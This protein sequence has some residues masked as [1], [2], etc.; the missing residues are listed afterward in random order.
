M[1]RPGGASVVVAAEPKAGG[2]IAAVGEVEP[3][4]TI[5]K[6]QRLLVT[7]AAPA[8]VTGGVAGPAKGKPD[9]DVYRIDVPGAEGRRG[10]APAAPPAGKSGAPPPP[11]TPPPAPRP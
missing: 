2:E 9:V 10:A 11:T 4:D 5:Q 8:A 6:A 3:N 7:P 1:P